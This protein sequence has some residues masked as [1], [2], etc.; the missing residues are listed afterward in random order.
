MFLDFLVSILISF[1]IASFIGLFFKLVQKITKLKKVNEDNKISKDSGINENRKDNKII[2]DL[3]NTK[4]S[5]ELTISNSIKMTSSSFVGFS[6]IVFSLLLTTG[7]QRMNDIT[8]MRGKE[9]IDVIHTIFWIIP[10]SSMIL[11]L[12]LTL[13]PV[14]YAFLKIVPQFKKEPGATRKIAKEYQT[15]PQEEILEK[16]ESMA[17]EELETLE[18]VNIFATNEL[19]RALLGFSIGLGLIFLTFMFGDGTLFDRWIDTN[20]PILNN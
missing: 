15:N 6:G 1:G 13:L 20:F 4:I 17:L 2:I 18:E 11:G 16:I 5:Q 10:L 14:L 8:I 9:A 12:V 7:I 19:K 3:I